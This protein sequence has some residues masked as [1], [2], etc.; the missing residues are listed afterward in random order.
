MPTLFLYLVKLSIGLAAVY[1]FYQLVLR[2]LTFY[3]YNRWY[4]LAYPLVCFIIPFIDVAPLLQQSPKATV[5]QWVPVLHQT[6]SITEAGSF[7]GWQLAIWILLA[8]SLIMLGRL[9][10]QYF[11]LLQIKKQAAPLHTD[12][13]TVYQVNKNIIPFS[14]ANGIY[15]NTHNHSPEEL[16]EIIRHEYVHVKERHSLD[17]LLGEL[18]CIINWFNPFVWLL[19]HAI[20]QNLEFVADNSVVESGI[21]KKAYQYL[22]LKV[23]GEP[24]FRIANQFN[25][26]SLK[27]RITMMNKIK[28]TKVHLLKFLIALPL[29]AVLLLAFRQQFTKKQQQPIAGTTLMAADTLPDE[30]K[31]KAEAEWSAKREASEQQFL[32][33]HP[34]VKS[35]D[36]AFITNVETDNKE[37]AEKYK[38]GPVLELYLTSGKKETYFLT[39]ESEVDRFKARYNELPPVAPPIP[40]VPP[41]PPA[42][43]AVAPPPAP[44]APTVDAYPAPAEAPT[45]MPTPAFAPAD[46]APAQAQ[47]AREQQRAA[48]EQQQAAR[49]QKQAG[50]D[51]A[52]AALAPPPPPAPV[53]L[54]KH[55]KKIQINNKKATVTLR[56]GTVE[57][58]DLNDPK[59][60]KDFSEKYGQLAPAPPPPAAKPYK[61]VADKAFQFQW[62]PA[63]PKKPSKD[64]RC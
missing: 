8:G 19:R 27:K 64:D 21:D 55:I 45:P 2:R 18:L 14:F 57:Q 58:Y 26:S 10:M 38:P 34:N 35:L 29:V 25:F 36:W 3:R 37:E 24:Q 53:K 42:F 44:A 41:T 15:V 32:R 13:I 6:V 11:S 33:R 39:N 28:S 43:E 40:T 54:P 1:L 17:I 56:N 48:W 59:E 5:L 12:G 49:N 60:G 4:L 46:P 16:Q 51:Q 62:M 7:N 50:Y 30:N 9:A 63:I 61:E 52:Q 31:Q 47:A 22:L 20:R 23:V